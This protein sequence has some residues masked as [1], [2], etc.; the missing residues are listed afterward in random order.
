MFKSFLLNCLAHNLKL[1]SRISGNRSKATTHI[2]VHAPNEGAYL[3][4][5]N[6][7]ES[8]SEHFEST[9]AFLPQPSPSAAKSFMLSLKHFTI[10]FAFA[11]L[12]DT[13]FSSAVL[14]SPTNE[15]LSSSESSSSFSPPS[16][17]LSVV[18]V[19]SPRRRQIVSAFNN[20]CHSFSALFAFV[21]ASPPVREP[22]AFPKLFFVVVVVVP[23]S[24]SKSKTIVGN[25]FS[26]HSAHNRAFSSSSSLNFVV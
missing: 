17:R 24:S 21:S 5:D 22:K 14:F 18:V 16:R 9:D 23:S 7:F 13:A 8:A 6:T 12:K 20:I 19:S 26:V 25:T 2:S 4:A 15:K 1:A 10:R 11:G 3:D